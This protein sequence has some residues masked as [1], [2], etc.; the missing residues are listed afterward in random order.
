MGWLTL[1]LATTFIL[2]LGGG[3][4]LTAVAT[5]CKSASP[6]SI[7]AAGQWSCYD[8]TPYSAANWL[9]NLSSCAAGLTAASAI[10]PLGQDACEVSMSD[11]GAGGGPAAAGAPTLGLACARSCGW[12]IGIT[13]MLVA[14]HVLSPLCQSRVPATCSSNAS[15]PSGGNATTCAAGPSRP[16]PLR[17]GPFPL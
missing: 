17:Q 12:C 1:A 7:C 2:T 3:T 15:S 10:A 4:Q 8:A 5:P 9:G 6:A 13:D 11:L 16:K 14:E